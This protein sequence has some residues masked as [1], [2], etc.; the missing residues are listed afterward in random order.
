MSRIAVL[1]LSG[2]FP[3]GAESPNALWAALEAGRDLV[4]EVPADR[5]RAD[6]FHRPFH[7][8]AVQPGNGLTHPSRQGGF[9][10]D[11]SGFD[12]AFFGIAP[13]E[14][15]AM[16]PAQRL[17]LEETW[18]CWED[19]G[20]PPS[21]W[22]ERPV[23]VFVGGFTQD[24]QL[25]QLGDSSGEA[26]SMH[27]ATGVMQ[28]LLSNRISH[29]FRF[30]GPS[31][32]VDTACS[33]SLVA[34]HLAAESLRRGECELALV[35][36]AQLQLAPHYTAIEGM[37]G[38]LSP[39]GRCR[40]FDRRAD[41]YVRAEAVGM[42]LL[43]PL[44]EAVRRG[45]RRRAEVVATAVNHNGR[46]PGVTLPDPAAQI[47]LIGAAL[48]RAGLS[49][50]EIGYVEAH[51]TGT[52][53]GDRAEA[54]ALGVALGRRR[55]HPLWIGSAKTN[56]GH[57][58]A[59]AGLV[60]LIKAI[61]CL[62]HRSIPP[63]LHWERTPDD[64]DLPGLGL[65][66]PLRSQPWPQAGRFAGVNSFGFGGTNA[67]AIVGPAPDV[68]RCPTV[69]RHGMRPPLPIAM[70]GPT[71]AHL[72]L[73]VKA[74]RDHVAAG[75]MTDGDSF[76]D[77]AAAALDRRPPHPHRLN[78]P[79]GDREA[80][81][82]AC[83]A[84][85]REP[86]STIWAQGE[87]VGGRRLVWVFAGMGP[88]WIA[89]GDGLTVA[90]PVYRETLEACDAVFT[91]L[92]GVSLLEETRRAGHAG[93]PITTPRLA[94]PLT[95][96]FQIALARLLESWGIK[97]DAVVGH[98]V[99][100]IAAFHAAG[101]LDLDTAITLAFHR[102]RLQDRLDGTGG[103]LVVRLGEAELHPRLAAHIGLAVAAVNSPTTI[104]VAGSRG[105]LDALAK[106]LKVNRVPFRRMDVGVPYHS[107]AMDA[108]ASE[109]RAA[110]TGLEFRAPQVPLAS[111]VTGT[112]VGD[113]PPADFA[114]YWWRNLREPVAFAAA[115]TALANDDG[116][117][118]QEISAH[119]TLLGHV[120]EC[121]RRPVVATLRRGTAD[122]AAMA[123]S[124]GRL[125]ALGVGPDWSAVAPPPETPLVLPA[126]AWDRHPH[127]SEAPAMRT[128]RLRPLEHPLLGVRRPGPDPTW[129]TDLTPRP[130]WN[131]ND[132]RVMGRP[133]VPAAMFIEMFDAAWRAAT[134]DA[135]VRFADLRFHRAALFEEG[136]AVVTTMVDLTL[137]VLRI[138]DGR[139][140][141][142]LA[143]ATALSALPTAGAPPLDVGEQTASWPYDWSA[144]RYYDALR[145]LG[146]DYGDSFRC[147]DGIRFTETSG[148]ARLSGETVPDLRLPPVLLD[149][150]LQ[151]MLFV[152]VAAR[153]NAS[154][155]LNDRVLVGVEEVTILRPIVEASFPLQVAAELVR[156]DEEETVGDAVLSDAQG[157]VLATLRGVTLHAMHAPSA[158]VG[159][160]TSA[161]ALYT[162]VWRPLPPV[163]TPAA[164][165]PIRHWTVLADRG[166]CATRFADVLA[167]IDGADIHIAHDGVPAAAEGVVIDFRALD[168]A[169]DPNGED[170]GRIAA[171]AARLAATCARL[172]PPARLWTVTRTAFA[173]DGP[174]SPLHRALWGLCRTVGGAERRE[175]FG[176]I[177]D[178]PAE[179]P[180]GWC[181]SL[182]A[183]LAAPPATQLRMTPAGSWEEPG[184]ESRSGT[185]A[186]RP[187]FRTDAGYLITGG[188]GAL[189]SQAADHLVEGGARALV[190]VGRVPLPPRSAWNG[191]LAPALRQRIARIR[192]LERRGVR[193]LALG[194]DVASAEGW[195]G[196]TRA[197][198]EA[199][200]PAVRGVVHTAGDLA[201]KALA[202]T[203]A[204]EL[205][206]V[207][208]PKVAGLHHLLERIDVRFLDFLLLYSSIASLLPAYGQAGYAAANAYLDG[209]AERLRRAGVPAVSLGWGPW[210]EGMAGRGDMAAS[211]RAR[212]F[213]PFTPREGGQLLE[214]VWAESAPAIYAVSADWP[215]LARQRPGDAW[216]FETLT[217]PTLPDAS[218]REGLLPGGLASLTPEHRE[219]VALDY[220]K[221]LAT[222]CLGMTGGVVTRDSVLARIGADSLM[223]VEMQVRIAADWGVE[224]AIS[225]LL[226]QQPLHRLA[227]RLAAG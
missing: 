127:W 92:S 176:G 55:T 12:A 222:R 216:L 34:L 132:H 220:M 89:M 153:T 165:P 180:D 24:Y 1:G 36:A 217:G 218:D 56:L 121:T 71:R 212:G 3:G 175:I 195:N 215:A 53:A 44:D 33:S 154:A 200:F 149:G 177:V 192:A 21:R 157:R 125:D 87:A 224:L 85:L 143:S 100:E 22:A 210:T 193:V 188:F 38:F 208:G 10:G 119:P 171:L 19:A 219:A 137:G 191:P 2:R 91:R 50:D 160:R 81:L 199:G 142:I 8:M 164:A 166:G 202:T 130:G 205:E 76:A 167:S 124:L 9:L 123:E 179:P 28:T 194:F 201:D 20:L 41:G 16:D 77:L 96:F 207:I 117:V 69:H 6:A 29:C 101:A 39:G 11:V 225:E 104:T 173:A 27:T 213:L 196:F 26:V 116:A 103:M 86:D 66:L 47:R 185:V 189:G 206:R 186:P 203:T 13:R 155:S 118:F 122:A 156:R 7:A 135:P 111:T 211:L 112:A 70:A 32:T 115:V 139:S 150:A 23:G 187:R 105:S 131:W 129:D 51:G 148:R 43:A 136:D 54:A 209:F 163:P 223:A 78:L 190:L 161:E 30:T 17:L 61:L 108:I 107:P 4:G 25:L 80:L 49:P 183:L 68:G 94:Q 198:E 5:W 126:Y 226:D 98:S 197:L 102:S 57:A 110:V 42:I 106:D 52:R 227:R 170:S 63:H 46:V 145:A 72:P 93:D 35:G 88:Q 151:A 31:L 48:E 184:L 174:G 90:R 204:E 64:I 133:R 37:G 62:E 74:M 83:D 75:G 159:G 60:G 172:A 114:E 14:A 58:E 82:A 152:E 146:H 120:T 221:Q 144:E 67:H 45:W 73:Q 158:F 162:P 40:A 168:E 147:I 84:Y 95:V 181:A 65:R 138:Q 109:F 18:R 59:A 182:A 113:L 169:A 99:G 178:L 97:P 79:A 214:R 128:F 140:G 134:G 15:D 141:D